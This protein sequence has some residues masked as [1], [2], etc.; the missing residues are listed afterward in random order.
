VR[1]LL[2]PRNIFSY[3]QIIIIIIIIIIVVV[4][5]VVVKS[6]LRR[7]RIRIHSTHGMQLVVAHRHV[8]NC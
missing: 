5:V 6:Q 8:C 3:A 2:D 7:Y 4:V 1:S